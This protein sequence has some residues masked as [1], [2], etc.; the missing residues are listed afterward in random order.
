MKKEIHVGLVGAQF[1]GR[2]HSNAYFKV[3]SAF[4]LPCRLVRR[5]VCRSAIS[6]RLPLQPWQR[7]TNGKPRKH[8]GN[9]LWPGTIWT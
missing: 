3:A 4:D 8:L 7:A 2:A 1:M 6:T 9:G 5:A